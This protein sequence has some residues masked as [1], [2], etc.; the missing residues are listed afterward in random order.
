MKGGKTKTGFLAG[1]LLLLLIAVP[2][3]AEQKEANL[4]NVSQTFNIEADVL[5]DAL[6]NY[7][8]VTGIKTVYLNE[9]VEGKKSPG[10]QG[11]YSSEDAVKKIL[12]GTS[13]TYEVT[14]ENTVVLKEAKMVVAQREVAEEKE[15]IKGPVEIEQMVVTAS[16]TEANLSAVPASVEVVTEEEIKARSA[17]RIRDILKLSTGVNLQQKEPF[18]RGFKGEHSIVMI[19]GK[20]I[21]G[22][23]DYSFELD[24]ITTEN[25]ERIEIVRGPMGAVY[26]SDALGGVI[27]IITKRPRKFSFKSQA[28]Y[29]QFDNDGQNG[30]LSFNLMSGG[31]EMGPWGVSLSGQIFDAKPYIQENGDTPRPDR[32]LKTGALKLTYDF[33]KDTVLTFD[34]SIMNEEEESIITST[35]GPSQIQNKIYDDNDRY[36]L[37]LGLSH[38]QQGIGAFFRIYTSIYD[39]Y[40]E[41]RYN[42]DAMFMGKQVKNGELSDF[43]EVDRWTRIAE[44]RISKVFFDDH[45]LT[46]GGEYRYE[47]FKGPW[48]DTG[49]GTYQVTKEGMT[50]NGSEAKIKYYAGYLQDEWQI[51]DR[52]LIV[53]A[54]R[55]DCSDELENQLSPKIGATFSLRPNFRIKANYGQGFKNPTPAELY[56][57]AYRFGKRIIGDPD[58]ESEKSKSY[59]AA[60][61]GE[62]GRLSYRTAYFYNDVKDLITK[63]MVEPNVFQYTNIDKAKIQGIEL[64]AGF[65]LMENLSIKGSYV[66]LDAKDKKT[67]KR[68]EARPRNRAILNT[69]YSSKDHG[70]RADF[71]LEYTGSYLIEPEKEES[72]TLCHLGLAKDLT[73]NLE[74]YVNVDN[75]FDKKVEDLEIPIIGINY[76]GG[77][78]VRF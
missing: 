22:E 11:I 7:S 54:L 2:A 73:K 41:T 55:Y 27:N 33:T 38:R 39:K 42:K 64:E 17:N 74:I 58:I 14:A 40:S 52:F 44:G 60:I 71:W 24:R 13:L 15:G 43:G 5:E 53:P 18:I 8:E 32:N 10:V 70:F 62:L 61:E 30:D 50:K 59:E 72:Y 29:G 76:F 37:S 3:M 65:D 45:F 9:L 1:I 19:D 20:R 57:N 26:G 35:M 48:L 66:Y 63:V 78:R 69:S 51:T 56:L 6:D 75:I 46:F 12:K 16:R 25:I 68:L 67:G 21:A 23:V 36:D 34:A 47:Y 31:D 49:E 4:M 77:I 28:Q